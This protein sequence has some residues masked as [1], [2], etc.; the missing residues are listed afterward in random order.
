MSTVSTTFTIETVD[1]QNGPW[2]QANT[3]EVNDIPA[4][5]TSTSEVGYPPAPP[6]PDDIALDEWVYLAASGTDI[7]VSDAAAGAAALGATLVATSSSFTITFTDAAATAGFVSADFAAPAAIAVGGAP[8][9]LNFTVDLQAPATRTASLTVLVHGNAANVDPG[10]H[11]GSTFP[12]SDLGSLY[13]GLNA[14]RTVDISVPSDTKAAAGFAD[15]FGDAATVTYP[16]AVAL[17]V[18]DSGVE[19]TANGVSIYTSSG[20]LAGDF[21]IGMLP[22]LSLLISANAGADPFSVVISDMSWSAP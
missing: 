10:D 17:I 21:A 19:V 7:A 13:V 16:V 8:F 11:L 22:L 15:S 4:G 12:E 9:T 5:E 14:G 3:G 2:Q 1:F 20:R 6:A 18:S